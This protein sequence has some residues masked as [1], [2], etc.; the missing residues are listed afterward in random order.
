MQ[1]PPLTSVEVKSMP[2][3]TLTEERPLRPGDKARPVAASAIGG[4]QDQIEHARSGLLL[5]R[6]NDLARFAEAVRRLLDD[7][8]AASAMGD[9]ARERVRDQFLGP[10]ALHDY[11]ELLARLLSK[12]SA[13][14][15]PLGRRR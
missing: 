13:T 11:L 6:P 3:A 14:S 7:D 9:A 15:E 10:R 5:D 1:A 2:L 4:I 8:R 12:P